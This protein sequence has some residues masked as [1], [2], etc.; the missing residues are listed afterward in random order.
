MA[1]PCAFIFAAE[2]DFGILPV[3]AQ[4]CGTQVISFGRGGALETLVDAGPNR[5]GAF[6][7]EATTSAIATAV[8]AFESGPAPLAE[9]YRANAK[10]FS[11]E[12]FRSEFREYVAHAWNV[13]RSGNAS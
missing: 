8:R 13:H 6:F 10:N 7:W 11:V 9:A 3:E 1:Y 5:N 2:E 4:A 12:R